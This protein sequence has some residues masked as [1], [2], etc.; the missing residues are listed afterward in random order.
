ELREAQ[1]LS[2]KIL[3]KAGLAVITD[4]GDEKDIHPTKKEPVG[5]RLALAAL[6]IAYRQNIVY[7]GPTFKKMAIKDDKAIISFNH[8][9]SGL[10]AR[11]HQTLKQPQNVAE[12]TPGGRRIV[13]TNG[14]KTVR[15][16]DAS[17]GD[18][19]KQQPRVNQAQFSPDGKVIVTS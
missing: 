8:V 5:A 13:M 7:S 6:G 10:E 19:V 1:M 2:T 18:A 4:V 12:F 14:D 15:I 16:W 9:G 3:P 11:T 17:T